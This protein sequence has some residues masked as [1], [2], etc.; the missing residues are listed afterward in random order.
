MTLTNAWA[1]VNCQDVNS[2]I[3]DACWRKPAHFFPTSEA[4]ENFSSTSKESKTFSVF[5]PD[6][7][8]LFATTFF[9]PSIDPLVT[10]SLGFSVGSETRRDSATI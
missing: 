3:K 8:L 2:K 10:V 5:P 9:G 6:D 7:P 1:Q 4:P